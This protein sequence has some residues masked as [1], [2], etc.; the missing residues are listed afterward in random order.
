MLKCLD[1]GHEWEDRYME[2]LLLEVNWKPLWLK[3]PKCGSRN[4]GVK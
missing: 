4:L 3:C 1:C 2:W